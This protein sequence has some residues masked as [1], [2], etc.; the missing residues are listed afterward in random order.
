MKVKKA[1]R[2]FFVIFVTGFDPANA[3]FDCVNA[4]SVK[5][6]LQ[7]VSLPDGLKSVFAVIETRC[8]FQPSPTSAP[9]VALLGEVF[10]PGG[11]EA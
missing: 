11:A 7:K 6:A 2:S 4:R 3:G 8:V 10:S 5:H 9:Y 1:A